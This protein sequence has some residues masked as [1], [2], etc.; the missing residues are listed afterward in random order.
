MLFNK[1]SKSVSYLMSSKNRY[2]LDIK[3]P[4]VKKTLIKYL[5]E[6]NHKSR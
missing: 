1:T 6:K 3:L 2:F 4:T 5:D